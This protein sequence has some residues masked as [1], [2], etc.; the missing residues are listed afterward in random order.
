MQCACSST[1]NELPVDLA[2]FQLDLH[3]GA[4]GIGNGGLVCSF[5]RGNRVRDYGVFD[6]AVVP[7][8]VSVLVSVLVV[9]AVMV[10]FA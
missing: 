5:V 3:D 7:M 2:S 6:R 9:G 4:A 10:G 8:S 1:G